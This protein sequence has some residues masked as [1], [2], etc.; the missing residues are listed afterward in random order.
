MKRRNRITTVA[1]VAAL[2]PLSLFPAHAQEKSRY[3]GAEVPLAAVS[4]GSDVNTQLF[5]RGLQ[6]GT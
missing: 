4:V 5:H 3:M 2:A 6:N 1:L